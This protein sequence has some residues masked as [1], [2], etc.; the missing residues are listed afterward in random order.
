ML[1]PDYKTF[2]SCF[3][4]NMNIS[5]EDPVSY[6]QLRAMPW[7]NP[8]RELS[9][10]TLLQRI[11]GYM[12]HV[13]SE[14]RERC[15]LEDVKLE[16]KEGDPGRWMMMVL[17][18]GRE[19]DLEPLVS[20][21]LE[22]SLAFPQNSNRDTYLLGAQLVRWYSENMVQMIYFLA[23]VPGDS[24]FQWSVNIVS[25]FEAAFE[26]RSE[27]MRKF[28][29]RRWARLRVTLLLAGKIARFVR[30]LFNEV[31]YRPGGQGANEARD[32]FHV[33]ANEHLE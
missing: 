21:V 33:L 12:L 13:M 4:G 31:H 1:R 23:A 6:E 11:R 15:R 26:R 14:S 16:C 25:F 20:E 3:T 8:V 2:N 17:L 19:A 29:V 10:E 32:D 30:T 24:R 5:V 18:R 22:T 28:A 7:L 9:T 27:I